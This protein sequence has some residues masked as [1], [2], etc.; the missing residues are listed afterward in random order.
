PRSSLALPDALPTYAS[1]SATTSITTFQAAG[2]NKARID[3][4]GKGYFNG[5]TQASGADF[6]E[7][8]GVNAA[9]KAF[10]P[11]DVIVIDTGSDRRLDRK[12]TRLN[13]SHEW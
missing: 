10:E 8:V 12:S 6:A 13:S 11:G 3:G 7:S 1:S 5:G 4:A 2:A 9:K